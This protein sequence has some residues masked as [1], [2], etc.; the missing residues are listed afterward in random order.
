MPTRMCTVKFT[1]WW[2]KN[3]IQWNGS[4]ANSLMFAV[5]WI[6]CVCVKMHRLLLLLLA[7]ST[8]AQSPSSTKAKA[9][10]EKMSLDEKI[11]MLHGG[12]TSYTGGTP[13]ILNAKTGV[14][15]CDLLCEYHRWHEMT[16]ALAYFRR[17]DPSTESKWRASRLSLWWYYMLAIS[18]DSRCNVWCRSGTK[19]GTG[20]GQRV[21][22]QGKYLILFIDRIRSF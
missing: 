9:M 22:R 14:R 16:W 17:Q 20:N 7:V 21:L 5:N 13:E 1:A 19:M 18:Y 8:K 6:S 2:N 3:S 4:D 15:Y 10:L 11:S 12:K